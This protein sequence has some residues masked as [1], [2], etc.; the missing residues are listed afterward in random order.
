MS[1]SV[2]FPFADHKVQ[3][4][5]DE[6]LLNAIDE[7]FRSVEDAIDTMCDQAAFDG[8]NGPGV[9]GDV[10]LPRHSA[11]VVCAFGW[12]ESASASIFI[13]AADLTLDADGVT[14][15][16]GSGT[17]FDQAAD[18]FLVLFRPTLRKSF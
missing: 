4:P 2:F 3:D 13:P 7:A 16:N 1:D 8:A 5:N 9:A 17:P 6:A 15:T 11:G 18:H 12:D 10:T 14:L